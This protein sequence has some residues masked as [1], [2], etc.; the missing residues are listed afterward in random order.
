MEIHG[1][2]SPYETVG[3][4]VYFGRMIDKIRLEAEG[5]LPA[6]YRP[7]LG[8]TN[9]LSFD[10]RCCRFL[11]IDFH[12]F[13]A[14]VVEG[15]TDDALFQWTCTHGQK[16]SEVE[17]EVWNA[18]MQK[19][20]WRDPSSGRLCQRK[21]EWG[22]AD[23]RVSSFFDFLDAD[24]GRSPRFPEDPPTN[25]EPVFGTARIPGLRSAWDKIGGIVHFGRM[26]DK[27]RLFQQGK[28]PPGWVESKGSVR[29]FDGSCCRFLHVEYAELEKET[30]SGAGDEEVLQWAFA[31]G[32]KPA[33]EEVDIWNDFLSKRCWRDQYVPRLLFRLQEAGMPSGLCLT[34][35]DLIDLEEGR[36]PMVHS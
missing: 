20:G 11:R 23:P 24:E 16:P 28:L 19:R 32:R 17:T 3:G 26:L 7:F 18:F 15:W 36:T 30:L 6:E 31:H 27:M 4:L 34:M 13:S 12:A 2:R 5:V 35:F 25:S 9:P 21:Q 8:G 1:L 22:I 33:D 14:R 29:G 10:A